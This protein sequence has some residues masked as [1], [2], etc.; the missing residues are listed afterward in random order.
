MLN[1]QP[2]YYARK[3]ISEFSRKPMVHRFDVFELRDG[4]S[5]WMFSLSNRNP[6]LMNELRKRG[7]P[8]DQAKVVFYQ[9]TGE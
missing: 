3:A 9:M 4:E 2:T 1:T 7:L 8:E 5:C 6:D